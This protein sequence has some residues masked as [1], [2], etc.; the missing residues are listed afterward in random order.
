MSTTINWTISHLDRKT[1]DGFVTTAHWRCDATDGD[2]FAGV[3]GSA[4]FSGELST[5]YEEL[6]EAQVLEWVWGSIDK[7]ETE[8]S[9]IKQIES[10]KHPATATGLPW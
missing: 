3:Y 9:V 7:E 2:Y 10:Q 6:T 5:P 8:S 4:G 1:E